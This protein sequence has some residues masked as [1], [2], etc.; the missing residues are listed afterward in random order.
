[1]TLRATAGAALAA[2]ASCTPAAVVA[3]AGAPTLPP[4]AEQVTVERAAPET[5][6]AIIGDFGFAGP[7]EA[8][9]SA[10]VHG[11]T[12]EFVLTTGDNNYN[13]GAASSIDANIGQYYHDF[14]APYRGSY[15]EG[16]RD[17]RFFPALGNHDWRTSSLKPFTD[18]FVLPGNERYYTVSIG[19]VDVFVVDSDPHEPDGVE[20]GST[21]AQW[22][23][24]SLAAADGPWKL[25]VMHHPPYSSGRHGS[26]EDLRWP[27]REWGATAVIAGH[28]HHYERVEV[29]GLLYFVN[30][31]GGN[32]NRY[33]V[34]TPIDGS[35][36]R[37]DDDHGAMRVSADTQGIRFEFITRA[38]VVVDTVV[39]KAAQ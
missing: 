30:G 39:R 26:E 34:N 20:V 2:L 35:V 9:V 18:Y 32:P 19:P 14:I 29:D 38:G 15:G 23:Q 31:L 37:F 10:L 21:Q 5:V 17:N 4:V 7:A 36:V 3:P 6:F 25:V 13:D 24:R 33:A 11:W 28:D 1:M 16:A 12:P 22:L 27:Y 8:D